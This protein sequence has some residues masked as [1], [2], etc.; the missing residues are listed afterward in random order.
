[1]ASDI[2]GIY[3]AFAATT[4]SV[5]GEACTVKDADELPQS[6]TTAVLPMRLLS[7]FDP[8]AGDNA[9]SETVYAAQSG[10]GYYTV[11]WQLSD[12]MYYE[13]VNQRIGVKSVAKD[14]LGYMADYA[15]MLSDTTRLSMP[16]S[17]DAVV[18][19]VSFVADI[20]EYPLGSQ[21][22]F[23]GVRVSMTVSEDIC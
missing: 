3:D 23:F 7:P 16:T 11:L 14:L 15:D 1:M 17:T 2:S 19:D 22:Y 18:G 10:S 5:G 9:A 8:F 13:A 12:L 20:L 21:H 6:L 4:V